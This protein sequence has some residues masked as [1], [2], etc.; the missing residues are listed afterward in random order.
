ML[1]DKYFSAHLLW[2]V[3]KNNI[4]PKQT[5]SFRI[6]HGFSSAFSFEYG[7]VKVVVGLHN[8]SNPESTAQFIP[9]QNYFQHESYDYDEG[10]N[11]LADDIMVVKLAVS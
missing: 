11:N 8:K 5:T 1:T 3:L 10:T 4:P 2:Y 7:D 6:G 9:A